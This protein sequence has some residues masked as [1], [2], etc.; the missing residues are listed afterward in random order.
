V[1]A[2]ELSAID[3][4]RRLGSSQDRLRAGLLRTDDPLMFCRCLLFDGQPAGAMAVRG[5][6]LLGPYLV[7]LSVLP[8]FQRQGLGRWMLATFEA[9]ARSGNARNLW[10]CASSFNAPAQALYQA[11]GFSAVADLPDL[12]V[13]GLDEVLMRKRLIG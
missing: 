7:H 12:I 5:G 9:E 3:P 13:D 4:W 11:L 1:L 6:W 8:A 2:P 10:V